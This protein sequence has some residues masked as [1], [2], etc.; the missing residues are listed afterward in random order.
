MIAILDYG[1]GNVNSIRN[2]LKKIGVDATLTNNVDEINDCEKIILPG[3][4]NFDHCMK[5]IKQAEFYPYLNDWVLI[6]KK[7][8]LGVCVGHQMLFE[9]SEEGSENGLGYLKGKVV[10]FDFE[11]QFTREFRVPHMEW[12]EILINKNSG[13]TEGLNSESKFYF[14]HSYYCVP[15]DESDILFSTD[16]GFQFVSA[17]ERG[18]IIGVQFHPEKS[19]K[20]GMQLY[21]NFSNN[22]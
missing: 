1:I 3:I 21:S 5:M 6:D 7:P 15:M 13:M 17:V 18:N 9:S 22:Y 16:Y 8:L 4:G 20:Y 10:K 14:V 2:M 19:H 12:N 11:N